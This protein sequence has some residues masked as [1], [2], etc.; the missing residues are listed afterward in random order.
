MKLDITA[1]ESYVNHIILYVVLYRDHGV[2]VTPTQLIIY[3]MTAR[4]HW[5]GIAKSKS[6]FRFTYPFCQGYD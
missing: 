2:L 6:D 5:L 3:L 1:F 4:Q